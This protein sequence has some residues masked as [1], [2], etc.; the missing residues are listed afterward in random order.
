VTL[1]LVGIA[2]IVGS[3]GLVT[4]IALIA[5]ALTGAAFVLQPDVCRACGAPVGA[6]FSWLKFSRGIARVVGIGVGSITLLIFGIG[7]LVE[8]TR[9]RGIRFE[10]ASSCPVA[11][12]EYVDDH[13]VQQQYRAATPW[14]SPLLHYPEGIEVLVLASAPGGCPIRCRIVYNGSPT[15]EGNG[16]GAIVCRALNR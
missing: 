14:T 4:A 13:G 6:A 1:V 11:T 3:R 7:L 8:L 15:I 16:T 2:A 10:I 5:A 12:V 9:E